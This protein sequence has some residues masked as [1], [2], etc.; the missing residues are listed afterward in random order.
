MNIEEIVEVA[1]N[2]WQ[3]LQSNQYITYNKDLFMS[4]FEK[5]ANESLCKK[6]KEWFVRIGN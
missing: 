6:E 2:K 5:I 4:Q 1:F 3:E